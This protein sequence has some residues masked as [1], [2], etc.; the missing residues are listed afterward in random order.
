MLR[1]HVH[2]RA[3]G[4]H[5]HVTVDAVEGRGVHGNQ[6]VRGLAE[7]LVLASGNQLVVALHAIDERGLV[8]DL[9]LVGQLLQ[10]VGLE[11]VDLPLEHALALN[12]LFGHVHLEALGVHQLAGPLGRRFHVV[13]VEH[14]AVVP[15]ILLRAQVAVHERHLH[16][17]VDEARAVHLHGQKRHVAHGGRAC[18]E[19]VQHLRVRQVLDLAAGPHYH[20][21]A[22]AGLVRLLG[23][24]VRHV[25]LVVVQHLLVVLVVA[26]RHDH[27]LRGVELHVAVL[28]LRDDAGHLATVARDQLLGGGGVEDLDA[29]LLGRGGQR[30]HAVAG[31][32]GL[33][34][35]ERGDEIDVVPL[36]VDE[37]HM[38]QV[39]LVDHLG[40]AFE[41]FLDDPLHSLAGVL[42]PQLY[43]FAIRTV[44]AVGDQLRYEVGDV[45]RVARGQ[46][47]AAARVALRDG[48]R[49]L[50]KQRHLRA[51]L[52]GRQRGR[53]A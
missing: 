31:V 25:G 53:H 18:V 13:A 17:L 30:A 14:L 9:Q 50:L 46:V 21:V 29:F 38:L 48:L 33:G 35:E 4:A 8:G 41:R 52:E 3:D 28:A 32:V 23:L 39:A 19:V 49:F 47:D 40:A 24:E 26:A 20:L 11:R 45:G 5:A 37:G 12:V 1:V 10:G 42:R 16:R 15:R 34:A 43:Q 27:A 51:R 2:A 44:L 36:L 7:V 22:V 6:V